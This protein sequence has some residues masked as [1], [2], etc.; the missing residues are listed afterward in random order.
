[1]KKILDKLN[2]TDKEIVEYINKLQVSENSKYNIIKTICSLYK[3]E[4]KDSTLFRNEMKK[5]K[6]SLINTNVN[7]ER[8][9]EHT[10]Q[11]YVDIYDKLPVSFDKMI[12]YLIS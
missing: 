10:L 9:T 6:E 3:Y 11:H 7:S 12:L 2:S 4:K 1:M 8:K 5:L